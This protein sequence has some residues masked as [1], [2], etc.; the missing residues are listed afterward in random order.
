METWE[1][2]VG[3][4]GVIMDDYGI[5]FLEAGYL[6]GRFPWWVVFAR[7]MNL[8][9]NRVRVV[10]MEVV[11]EFRDILPQGIGSEYRM[12]ELGSGL[13]PDGYIGRVRASVVF[14]EEERRLDAGDPIWTS[15]NLEVIVSIVGS[16]W[17]RM[18]KGWMHLHMKIEHA[19]CG[20]VS[21]LV[22]NV[23]AWCR[24]ERSS[25]LREL[26]QAKPNKPRHDMRSVVKRSP[27]GTTTIS[28][29]PPWPDEPGSRVRWFR[30]G[31][32]ADA[33]GLYP[34]NDCGNVEEWDMPVR[35]VFAEWPKERH[36]IRKLKPAEILAVLDV[37]EML[38]LAASR[39]S[40][41]IMA[42]SVL[43][44][45]KSRQAVAERLG[46]FLDEI[47]AERARGRKKR[48]WEDPEDEGKFPER[49]ERSAKSQKRASWNLPT[50]AS[51][52]APAGA[53][54]QVSSEEVKLE[55]GQA[56]ETKAT[57]SDDAQA[58][59]ERWNEA[60]EEGLELEVKL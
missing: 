41:K 25:R 53:E 40:W 55:E 29:S 18:P 42:N 19:T 8:D 32:I 51:Q 16:G 6:G 24:E 46:V 37:P 38:G 10:D 34:V 45:L 26:F 49:D 31:E 20:G 56:A 39:R 23:Y 9:I 58:T 7:R 14:L 12:W 54:E 43:I 22:S 60:V 30:E 17:G 3:E 35:T 44:P 57:K 1:Y 27:I 13:G 5:P 50:D 59:V 4:S 15:P 47:R 48:S 33:A 28:P 21:D 11:A 2:G 36:C 52:V